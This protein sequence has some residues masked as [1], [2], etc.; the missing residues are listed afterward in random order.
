MRQVS[1]QMASSHTSSLSMTIDLPQAMLIEQ[2]NL[3]VDQANPKKQSEFSE[4]Y[5]LLSIVTDRSELTLKSAY[6][7]CTTRN[8]K[9]EYNTVGVAQKLTLVFAK[10]SAEAT[11]PDQI[12]I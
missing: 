12:Q 11:S 10:L 9:I 3:T 4:Q 2:V 1:K 7:E 8:G 6:S 5:Q